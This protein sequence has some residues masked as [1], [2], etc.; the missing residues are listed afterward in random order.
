MRRISGFCISFV[1]ASILLLSFSVYPVFSQPQRAQAI[2]SLPSFSQLVKRIAPAVVNISTEM[3]VSPRENPFQDFF[4]KGDERFREFFEKFFGEMPEKALKRKALGSGFIIDKSGLILTNSHVV[5]K[6]T[7][8]TVVTAD[9]KEYKAKVIGTDPKTDLALISITARDVDLPY[10]SLGDSDKT[11]VGDWVISIGNPLGLAHTVTQGIISAKGRFLGLGP[12]DNF[13]Q[14]DAPVNP[15]NSGGPLINLRGEV[16]GVTTAMAT[17]Q[18]IAFAIP[19]NTARYVSQQLREKGKVTRGYIGVSIQE[20]TQELAKGLGLKEPRGALVGDVVQ[21][22]PADRGGIRRGDVIVAFAEKPIQTANDLP[23]TVANTPVSR[24]VPVTVIREGKEM[25][26]QVQVQ[27][28]KDEEK[29]EKKE[30]EK[31]KAPQPKDE[32]GVEVTDITEALQKRLDL[33]EKT[34]VV[35]VKVRSGSPSSRA[36]IEQGD[37]ILSVN[38]KQVSN[39]KEFRAAVEG[40]KK[41]QPL[42]LLVQ[43]EGVSRFLTV[44]R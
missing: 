30:Q 36:G 28:L 16:I 44:E 12:Y 4:G 27:E 2:E 20:V 14:T 42:L 22:G 3:S 19:S 10:L 40:S 29:K 8:I 17:A 9:E 13:L 39:V 23:L 34:G 25:T 38:R 26:L 43:R 35:V 18:A 6:A 24:T 37:V 33:K 1:L 21:G 11:E 15:G 32:L 5:Q 41:G 31:E 7:D